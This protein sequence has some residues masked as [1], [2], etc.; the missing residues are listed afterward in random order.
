MR[1]YIAAECR[2]DRDDY[3]GELLSTRSIEIERTYALTEFTTIK[4]ACF[5]DGIYQALLRRGNAGSLF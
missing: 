2:Y 5:S 3:I 4:L 1:A